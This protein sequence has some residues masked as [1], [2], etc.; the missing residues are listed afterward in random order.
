MTT[1]DLLW[2]L[3]EKFLNENSKDNKLDD[4]SNQTK[5]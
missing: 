3:I 4:Q 5:D 2:K 1:A